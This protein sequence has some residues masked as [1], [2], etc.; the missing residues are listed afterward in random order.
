MA[1]L[2][3]Q[4]PPCLS[5]AS[6]K[7]YS[8]ISSGVRILRPQSSMKPLYKARRSIIIPRTEAGTLAPTLG[9]S[10]RRNSI[11]IIFRTASISVLSLAASPASATPL[12][13]VRRSPR[14]FWNPASA[15]FH[16]LSRQRAQKESRTAV[17]ATRVTRDL[18]PWLGPSSTPQGSRP[19]KKSRMASTWAAEPAFFS[20]SI[21]STNPASWG[22]AEAR[23]K[24]LDRASLE[25]EV[26]LAA[27]RK[28][29][30]SV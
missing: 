16:M 8:F 6:R 25:R 11:S 15:F 27:L 4:S 5:K 13:L 7:R 9:S 1:V 12:A 28:E 17:L 14:T 29:S 21:R 24:A 30:M 19:P 26:Y 2:M 3:F 18:P 10:K 20:S 22:S 23:L